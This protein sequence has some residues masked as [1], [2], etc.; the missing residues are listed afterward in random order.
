MFAP[1]KGRENP[2]IRRAL[3]ICEAQ[4]FQVIY[5]EDTVEVRFGANNKRFYTVWSQFLADAERMFGERLHETKVEAE[6]AQ[7]A[8]PGFAAPPQQPIFGQPKAPDHHQTA[9]EE[10]RAL[11][12]EVR[13]LER[14][15]RVSATQSEEW[16]KEVELLKRELEITRSDI[17]HLTDARG[18]GPGFSGPDRYKQVRQIIVRRLHPDIPGTDLEKAVREKLFKTIWSEIEVLDNKR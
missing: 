16:K 18:T 7:A 17:Q 5:H 14:A 1:K 8:Q 2:T 6:A 10:V 9:E 4:G 13:L 15:V 3:D 12:R 11:K